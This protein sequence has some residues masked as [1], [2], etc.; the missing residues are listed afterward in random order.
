MSS[1]RTKRP[2]LQDR[3]AAIK[4]RTHQTP[5]RI[6]RLAFTKEKGSKVKQK[7]TIDPF[8]LQIYVATKP[9]MFLPVGIVASWRLSRKTTVKKNNKKAI[10][11]SSPPLPPK[12]LRA[13]TTSSE[14][15]SGR[16]VVDRVATN[17]R[18]EKRGCARDVCQRHGR[19][20]SY[21]NP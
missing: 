1:W 12:A 7:K 13:S 4:T 10:T 9:T 18:E 2:E 5:R 15:K 6:Y 17:Q 8:P 11:L 14:R 21:P 16:H 20:A 19:V 3:R